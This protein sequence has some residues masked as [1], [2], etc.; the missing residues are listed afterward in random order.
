MTSVLLTTWIHVALVISCLL[1]IPLTNSWLSKQM[2]WSILNSVCVPRRETFEHLTTWLEDARQHSSSNMVIMLIGNKRYVLLL[3]ETFSSSA[4]YKMFPYLFSLSFFV[5][6]FGCQER[7][8]SRR[9]MY[10]H[11]IMLTLLVCE[12]FMT[13]QA[14]HFLAANGL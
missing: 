9:G 7:S 3:R 13:G 11:T 2:C 6:W 1:S 8:K 10:R 4:K 12:T 14:A 5:Q